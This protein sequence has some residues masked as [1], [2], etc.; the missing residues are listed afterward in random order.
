MGVAWPTTQLSVN[1]IGIYDSAKKKLWPK[2][3]AAL[4][5]DFLTSIKK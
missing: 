1:V 5:H 2:M 3:K 4:L